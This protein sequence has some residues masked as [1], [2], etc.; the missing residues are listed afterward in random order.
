MKSAVKEGKKEEKLVK[1]F[2]SRGIKELNKLI[3]MSDDVIIAPSKTQKIGRWEVHKTPAWESKH[4]EQ[5]SEEEDIESYS[6][7]CNLVLP[8]IYEISIDKPK[9]RGSPIVLGDIMY[10][11]ESV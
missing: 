2:T 10:F 7:D 11:S 8:H 9:P 1:S 5:W 3:I 4:L 6:S